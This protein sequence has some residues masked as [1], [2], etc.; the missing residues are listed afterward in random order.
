ML[1]DDASVRHVL[2]T[3]DAVGGVWTYALELASQLARLGVRTTLATMGE[4]LRRHQSEEARRVPGLKLIEG[5]YKLEWMEDPWE[6]L[7]TAGDWLL[8]I[9]ERECPDVVHLNGYSLSPLAWHAPRL[10]V[11]HSCVVSWWKAVLGEDAPGKYARYRKAVA[12][13]LLAADAVVA[14]TR[15]MVQSL[16]RHYGAPD[17]G[18]VIPNGVSV[19]RFRI[20]RKEPFVLAAG[21]IWDQAKNLG[22]LA[23]V[24]P[25]LEWPVYLAGST[26]HPEGTTR[27]YPGVRALGWIE[28]GVLRDW[29]ARASIYAFPARYEPFG[30][31]VLEAALS[32]CALVLGDIPTL[33][34]V[35]GESALYVPPDDEQGLL[36][37]IERLVE[38][39]ASRIALAGAARARAAAF[40]AERMARRYVALYRELVIR[41]TSGTGP[42]PVVTRSSKEEGG[43]MVRSCA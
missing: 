31:S 34:E 29:M 30:L 25:H 6:D 42:A 32:G 2:M 7:A 23:A 22:A 11:A 40:T 28:P 26:E 17:R 8:G 36:D 27:R 18:R 24:A 38:D 43:S 5:D 1:D 16:R 33:R 10:V 3:A 12:R 4:P 21:R 41:R 9:E 35:W 14:P 39:P 15:A 19:E 37:A 20:S 13:G